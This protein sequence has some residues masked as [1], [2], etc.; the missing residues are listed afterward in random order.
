MMDNFK[1]IFVVGSLPARHYRTGAEISAPLW[2]KILYIDGRLSIT[3]YHGPLRN[4][5]ALSLIH[6]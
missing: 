3:G 1:R 4:G 5:E 6:I 2:V